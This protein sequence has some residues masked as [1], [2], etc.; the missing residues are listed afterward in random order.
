[1]AGV[2]ASW[3]MMVIERGSPHESQYRGM[4]LGALTKCG[5]I[6]V[7]GLRYNL[8]PAQPMASVVL[9]REGGQPIAMYIVPDDADGDYR[10]T[11]DQL[12]SESEME[13]WIWEIAEGPMPDL[14]R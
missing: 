4:L 8:P 2:E 9:T 13:S 11:L 3:S 1:M 12:V 6:F 14:P 7:K 5:S 10:E